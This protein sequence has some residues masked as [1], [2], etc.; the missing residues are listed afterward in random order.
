[1]NYEEISFSIISYAGDAFATMREA[2]NFAKKGE[3]EKAEETFKK[4]QDILL[5]AHNVHTKLIVAETEGKTPEFSILLS[6]AQDTMMN[7]ILFE[8]ITEEFIE[9]YK[10]K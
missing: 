8:T 4:A 1:M 5:E 6:H 9:M 10:N 7:A 3:F 2:I